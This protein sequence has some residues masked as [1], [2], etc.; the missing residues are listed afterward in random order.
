MIDILRYKLLIVVLLLFS[1]KKSRQLNETVDIEKDKGKNEKKGA[2]QPPKYYYVINN[3]AHLYEDTDS[4]PSD[5]L[6]FLEPIKVIDYKLNRNG[7][8]YVCKVETLDGNIGYLSS[9]DFKSY[10]ELS[11]RFNM[12]GLDEKSIE[13]GRR[14]SAKE[15][16]LRLIQGLDNRPSTDYHYTIFNMVTL[17]EEPSFTSEKVVDLKYLAPVEVME[18][19]EGKE[20]V[21]VE[22][23]KS[24]SVQGNWCKVKILNGTQGYVFDGFIRSFTQLPDK[25]L[26]KGIETDELLINGKLKAVTSLDQFIDVLGKPDSIRYYNIIEGYNEVGDITR[27]QKD[28][29]LYVIENVDQILEYGDGG[30]IYDDLRVHFYYKAGIEYEELEGEVS[31]SNIDFTKNNNFLLYNGFKID[32]STSFIE[33]AKLFPIH[34][35]NARISD[36]DDASTSYEFCGR[37]DKNQA[38]DIYWILSCSRNA[39][40]FFVYWYD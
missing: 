9:E 32:S 12:E 15:G 8:A 28:G 3:M 26:P 10:S 25:L 31:F 29:V 17:Y 40:Q 7:D 16:T 36:D 33:I 19:L 20:E 14:L 2:V 11:D 5:T 38:A 6:H 18:K 4:E 30:W 23:E 21:V 13:G 1:C 22:V 34:T 35:I 27:Q 37:R 39:E 24:E